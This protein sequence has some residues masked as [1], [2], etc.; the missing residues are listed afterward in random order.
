MTIPRNSKS[1]PYLAIAQYY[2]V[3]YSR[4]LQY[5]EKLVRLNMLHLAPATQWRYEVWRLEKNKLKI[6][7]DI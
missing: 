5:S 3:D 7:V 1:Y 6:G 4:V 2:N